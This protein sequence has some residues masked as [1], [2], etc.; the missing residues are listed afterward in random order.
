MYISNLED[1]SCLYVTPKCSFVLRSLVFLMYLLGPHF[2]MSWLGHN[3]KLMWKNSC[4]LEACPV[5]FSGLP[6][7]TKNQVVLLSKVAL[8]CPCGSQRRKIVQTERSGCQKQRTLDWKL[9]KLQ[10]AFHRVHR[11]DTCLHRKWNM[12]IY[13][14]NHSVL[15]IVA[16][17]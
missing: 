2:H 8:K 3:Q 16:L 17:S 15:S 1:V 14:K 12:K 11:R 6:A 10:P 13:I 5:D 7:P 4:D 9:R